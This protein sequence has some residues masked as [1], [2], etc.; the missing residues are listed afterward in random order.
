[1]TTNE[2]GTP[3]VHVSCGAARECY[4]HVQPRAIELDCSASRGA[5]TDA[6]GH[7]THT[8]PARTYIVAQP[9]ALALNSLISSRI[10]HPGE[11]SLASLHLLL[12]P[13]CRYPVVMQAPFGATRV[14]T[15]R[16]TLHTGSALAT[17][18]WPAAPRAAACAPDHACSP[19]VSTLPPST[20]S[21]RPASRLHLT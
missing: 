16:G 7:A 15:G 14:I 11:C 17:R 2:C 20:D 18:S 3:S 10:L 12:W 6:C 8:P 21:L 4:H 5:E 9:V 1:M 19:R 13:A